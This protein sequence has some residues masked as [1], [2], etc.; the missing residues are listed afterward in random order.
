MLHQHPP[1]CRFKGPE[2]YWAILGVYVPAT[3]ADPE[4]VLIRSL[5]LKVLH[6]SASSCA[7]AYGD[8]RRADHAPGIRDTT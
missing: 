5:V 3:L 2:G 6:L 8:G 1:D 4:V 7:G